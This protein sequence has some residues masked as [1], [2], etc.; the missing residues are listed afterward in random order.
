MHPQ[1]APP[2]P[3]PVLMCMS[4]WV[5][6]SPLS[7]HF[8]EFTC[9]SN[10]NLLKHAIVWVCLP[11]TAMK[12]MGEIHNVACL[13]TRL[14][15]PSYRS[16]IVRQWK[17]AWGCAVGVMRDRSIGHFKLKQ[18]RAMR[19]LLRKVYRVQASFIIS[20]QKWLENQILFSHSM[21]KLFL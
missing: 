10:K 3:L 21:Y 8:S 6:S 7:S 5:T 12:T 16:I 13:N 19:L 17:V 14:K 4:V 18:C 1:I 9:C 20:S 2:P 11:V 15:V